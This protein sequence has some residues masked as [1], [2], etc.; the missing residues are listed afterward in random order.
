MTTDVIEEM[1][2]ERNRRIDRNRRK[3]NRLAALQGIDVSRIPAAPVME[4]LDELTALGWSLEAV[5][6]MNGAG[7]NKALGLIMRG[8]TRLVHRKFAP[9]L[10]LKP[11]LAVPAAVPDRAWVPALG[12]TRR[13]R[14]LLALGWRHDDIAALT[15][16]KNHTYAMQATHR[17]RAEHWRDIDDAFER[18]SGRRGPSE[19]VATRSRRLGYAPPLAW[20]DID[21]PNEQ[22]TGVRE[23]DANDTRLDILHDHIERGADLAD[24]LRE[25]R[26]ERESLRRW[27]ERKGHL[28]L[29]HTLATRG[30]G[31]DI[32]RSEGFM[33]QSSGRP[34]TISGRNEGRS[35]ATE[36]GP[37]APASTVT[38]RGVRSV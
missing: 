18:L 31:A 13:I 34:E 10:A 6:A 2:R 20:D 33:G 12:A 15:G 27:C 17:I 14:A 21:D 4:R 30:Q 3:R 1:R 29:Y 35:A 7:T 26:I 16:R 8:E 32:P 37:L 28:G 36:T 22:P 23:T 5:A 19:L 38:E 9:I 11:T 24:A 25:L